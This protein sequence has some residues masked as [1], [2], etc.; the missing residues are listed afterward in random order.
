MT[1]CDT[2]KNFFTDLRDA[3]CTSASHAP[4]RGVVRMTTPV[5][6]F[7]CVLLISLIAVLLDH[8]LCHGVRGTGSG[9]H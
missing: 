6:I 5:L 7:L 8:N 4:A 3:D 9:S 1:P 2:D